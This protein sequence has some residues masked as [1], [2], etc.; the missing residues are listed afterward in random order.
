M[1]KDGYRKRKEELMAEH[2]R[3]LDNL[4][5]LF[6]AENKKYSV[7]DEVLFFDSVTD[8]ECH[9]VIEDFRCEYGSID[10]RIASDALED[11]EVLWRSQEFIKPYK[12]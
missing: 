6:M 11:G 9:G 12:F 4:D 7:G 5:R 3:H 1:T 2:S 10:Y 8:V